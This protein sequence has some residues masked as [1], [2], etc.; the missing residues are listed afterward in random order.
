MRVLEEAPGC[1]SIS[2][3]VWGPQNQ[4]FVSAVATK[5]QSKTDIQSRKGIKQ[6]RKGKRGKKALRHTNEQSSKGDVLVPPFCQKL[7]E[8][9]LGCRI[10]IFLISFLG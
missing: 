9:L 8:L 7:R 4:Y 3:N 6:Q 2:T 1:G 10:K 5:Q